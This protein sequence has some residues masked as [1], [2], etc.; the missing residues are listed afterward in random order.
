MQPFCPDSSSRSK[1]RF[2]WKRKAIALLGLASLAAFLVVLRHQVGLPELS[3]ELLPDRYAI[4]LFL[5]SHTIAA[6]VGIPGT[7]LV[8]AGG[9]HFGLV[10]GT[11]WSLLG[12][13]LGA[14]AAFYLARSILRSWV[15]RRF[16]DHPL[17]HRINHLSDRHPMRCVLAVRFIPISPFSIVNFLFGLTVIDIKPYALGTAIGIIPGTIGYTWLGVTGQTV[18]GGGQI[19]PLAIACTLLTGL[20]FVPLIYRK[21]R[22][23]G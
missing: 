19:A 10:W 11:V 1:S 14:I 6:M 16:H 5:L 22:K 8:I 4:P 17:M 21:L 2:N 3:L 20:A 7:A 12:A 13:T 9:A 23:T 18:L 15:Y